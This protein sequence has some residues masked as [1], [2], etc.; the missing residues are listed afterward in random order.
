M[1]AGHRGEGRGDAEIVHLGRPSFDTEGETRGVDSGQMSR[2]SSVKGALPH[3]R[4]VGDMVSEAR[5]ESDLQR[6]GAE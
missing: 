6:L 2:P 5:S 1:R 3:E 4:R